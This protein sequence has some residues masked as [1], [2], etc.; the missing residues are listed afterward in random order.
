MSAILKYKKRDLTTPRDF[1]KLKKHYRKQRFAQPV[2]T[3]KEIVLES[4][5]YM[6]SK[7]DPFGNIE[8]CNSYFVEVSGYAEHELVGKPHSIVRHPDMPGAIF[9]LLWDHLHRRK[10]VSL[11]IKSM[12]KDGSYYWTETEINVIVNKAIDEV[13]GYFGYQKA[14]PQHVL[15]QIEEL[16]GKL[17]KIEKESRMEASYKYL[18]NYLEEREQSWEMYMD[19]LINT[20]FIHRL[21]KRLFTPGTKESLLT[22]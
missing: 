14:A 20:S 17:L 4:R 9:E 10:P 11:I 6:L 18:C 1:D 2:P 16:Y 13:E 12:A 7:T 3:D 21:K 15:P 19:E 8:Y 22:S 5:K